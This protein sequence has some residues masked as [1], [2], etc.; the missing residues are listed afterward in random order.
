MTKN[1]GY[2]NINTNYSRELYKC[3]KCN[4]QYHSY[5]LCFKCDNKIC[6]EIDKDYLETHRCKK[7]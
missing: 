5:H 1:L 2:I 6:F 4:N 3:L 7:C